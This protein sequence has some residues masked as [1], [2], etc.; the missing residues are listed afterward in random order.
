MKDLGEVSYFLDLEISK[1]DKWHFVSQHKY[2]LD[3]LKE[4][5]MSNATPFKV[6]I[7]VH[8]KLILDKGDHAWS[9]LLSKI[10]RKTYILTI[11]RPDISYSVHILTQYLQS[12]SIVRLPAAKR[13][14]MY[15]LVDPALRILL[16]FKSWAYLT[17]FC[18]SDRVNCAC[19]RRSTIWFLYF[20][21][22]LPLLENLR[23]VC[24]T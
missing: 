23:K 5:N 24:N 20:L 16:A 6:L 12:P 7:N 15:L 8:L 19:S 1:C 2:V 17:T 14:L 18:D 22:I 10:N 9:H 21:E 11:T 13:V 3:M 4:F